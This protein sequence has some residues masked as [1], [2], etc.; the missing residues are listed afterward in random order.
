MAMFSLHLPARPPGQVGG[1]GSSG[2]ARDLWE[3]VKK[4]RE[5]PYANASLPHPAAAGW[6]VIGLP[7]HLP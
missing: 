3:S 2:G 7:A 4:D 6:V 1:W 5:A